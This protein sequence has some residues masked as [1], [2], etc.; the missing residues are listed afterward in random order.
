MVIAVGIRR[1]RGER[2]R[3]G[4]ERRGSYAHI[5]ALMIIEWFSPAP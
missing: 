3:K 4:R 5:F 1:E 2:E